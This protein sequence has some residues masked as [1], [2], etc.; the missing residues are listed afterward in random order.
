MVKRIRSCVVTISIFDTV[1]EYTLNALT[2][3][4]SRGKNVRRPQICSV[5]YRVA[6]DR[7]VMRAECWW[8]ASRAVCRCLTTCLATRCLTSSVLLHTQ[9]T[10]A[11]HHL[12]HVYTAHKAVSVWNCNAHMRHYVHYEV[13][14]AGSV[15]NTLNCRPTGWVKTDHFQKFITPVYDNRKMGRVFGPCTM[16]NTLPLKSTLFSFFNQEK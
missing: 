9:T 16:Y 2:C 7:P 8:L 4:W 14:V 12:L 11:V 13:R 3:N 1:Q 10:C 5:A 15:S 6:D